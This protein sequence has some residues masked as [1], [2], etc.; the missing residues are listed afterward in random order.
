MFLQLIITY[1]IRVKAHFLG[2]N[3]NSQV[4]KGSDQQQALPTTI[5]IVWIEGR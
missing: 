3:L 2:K 5:H 4:K 1:Q